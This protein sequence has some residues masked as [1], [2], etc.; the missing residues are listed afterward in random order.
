[1]SVKDALLKKHPPNQP[2]KPSTIVSLSDSSPP[3]HPV[4]FEGMDGVLIR[5]TILC[6]DGAAGPSGLDVAA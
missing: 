3:F 2:P 5:R 1:M 6:M 4:V